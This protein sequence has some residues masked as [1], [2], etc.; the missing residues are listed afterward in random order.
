M[1]SSPIG[2]DTMPGKNGGRL[3]VLTLNGE[4]VAIYENRGYAKTAARYLRKFLA[5]LPAA[6][7]VSLSGLQTGLGNYL[8]AASRGRGVTKKSVVVGS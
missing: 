2:T 1:P 3:G 6:N 7:S 5:R 4:I 8:A